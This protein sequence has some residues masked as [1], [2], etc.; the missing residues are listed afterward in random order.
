[1]LFECLSIDVY[2]CFFEVNLKALAAA[3]FV[4][5]EEE[6]MSIEI[7]DVFQNNEIVWREIQGRNGSKSNRKESESYGGPN[8]CESGIKRHRG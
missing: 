4:H 8:S 2:T 7:R 6:S 5:S 3:G 1:M